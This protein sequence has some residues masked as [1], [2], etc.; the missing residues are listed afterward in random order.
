MCAMAVVMDIAKL[1]PVE[2]EVTAMADW[3]GA[4]TWGKLK[5]D[6]WARASAEMGEEGCGDLM[7]IAAVDN[8]EYRRVI[9]VVA[10]SGIAKARLNVCVNL[11]QRKMGLP[12]ESFTDKPAPT[13]TTAAGGAAV[14]VAGAAAVVGAGAVV[15][16]VKAEATAKT[17]IKVSQVFD[18]GCRYEVQPVAEE[19][20]TVMRNRWIDKKGMPPQPHMDMSDTQL[21]TLSRLAELDHNLLAFDMA[22]WGPCGTQRERNFM[23]AA[24]V[25]NGD[26][27][28]IVK[29]IAGARSMEDWRDGWEFATTAMVM[30]APH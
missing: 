14:S 3:A 4:M 2:A 6:D 1:F 20:L 25:Q 27:A 26:G 13:A 29:E 15:P 22:V 5:P 28:W 12:V 16:V 21:S 17:V 8:V 9:G 24:H 10:L 19:V 7:T 11:V 23:M 30:G 18:Q